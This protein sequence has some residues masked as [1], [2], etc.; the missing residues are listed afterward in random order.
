MSAKD[1]ARYLHI[2]FKTYLKPQ[3]QENEEAFENLLR[4]ALA[5]R[6][7]DLGH[8]KDHCFNFNTI[9]EYFKQKQTLTTLHRGHYLAEG[10]TVSSFKPM[11]PI[12]FKAV[13]LLGLGEG[14]FPTP[15]QRDTLD[16]RYIPEKIFH[17]VKKNNFRERRIGDVSETE[18]DR[19][20]FLETLISTRKYLVLSYVS[21][22]DRTD[23]ELSPS[24]IIQTLI[25]EL[26]KGYLKNKFNVTKHPLKTYS[27]DYFPELT[28]SQR[29]CSSPNIK[30]P[31]YDLIAFSQARSFKMRELLDKK[32]PDSQRIPLDFFPSQVNDSL[33]SKLIPLKNLESDRKKNTSIVSISSLRKFLESPLQTSVRSIIKFNEKQSDISDKII[34]P[35][36]LER[37]DEWSLLRKIWQ[38]TLAI[39]LKYNSKSESI[40]DWEKSYQSYSKRMEL[41][42]LLPTGIFKKTMQERH[43]KILDNWQKKLTISLKIDWTTLQKNLYQIH[44][45]SIEDGIF[46]SNFINNYKLEPAVN[47]LEKKTTNI[48]SDAYITKI[49]GSSEWWY[50]G[51]NDIWYVIFLNETPTKEKNWLRHFLDV[52]IL[53]LA[54]FLPKNI[55]VKGLCIGSDD[56]V[57]S[58]E[59]K[60]PSKMQAEE[61]LAN[62]FEEMNNLDVAQIMPIESVFELAK[63]KLNE[64]NY[65]KRFIEWMNSKINTSKTNLDISSKYGPVKFL[66]DFPY[67]KN[68]YLIMNRRF[69]LFF[70]TILFPT[71]KII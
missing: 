58:R 68:P 15:Y 40:P 5:I 32:F 8:E 23:D 3:G 71:E 54:D 70:E 43:L 36:V 46:D 10:I 25:D 67:P 60:I 61:Y 19:Y 7:L 22:N 57:K 35:F 29:V 45:G 66:E 47:V 31:N 56:I 28:N 50:T 21:H 53:K 6:D 63:E 39:P 33:R 11:R 1:W 69:K 59:I 55:K 26:D 14:L 30:L 9:L 12:P 17:S 13:F 48:E 49:R 62:L 27:L 16:L 51:E 44:L 20:M 34:E 42:G 65:N 38:N 2:L 18:R 41:E 64:S 4:N 37:L 24:S 52:L